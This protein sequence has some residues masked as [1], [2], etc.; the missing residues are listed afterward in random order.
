MKLK[1]NYRHR[2]KSHCPAIVV[3]VVALDV[4]GIF[5]MMSLMLI[6]SF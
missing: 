6:T 2:R 1:R 5:I 4:F 3:E